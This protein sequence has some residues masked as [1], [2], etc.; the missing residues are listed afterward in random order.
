MITLSQVAQRRYGKMYNS[1]NA[2]E[3]TKVKA[4]TKQANME[5]KAMQRYMRRK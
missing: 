3:K 4:L 1:L 2:S 5:A